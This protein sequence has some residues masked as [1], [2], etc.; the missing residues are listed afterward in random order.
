MF[1]HLLASTMEGGLD[2]NPIV[3]QNA[4]TSSEGRSRPAV[5]GKIWNQHPGVAYPI[6]R[7]G[8]GARPSTA[9]RA[10]MTNNKR[11][12]ASDS[13]NQFLVPGNENMFLTPHQNQFK[14]LGLMSDGSEMRAGHKASALM[15]QM[16][17][18]NLKRVTV[19]LSISPMR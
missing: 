10:I 5:L 9:R 17:A 1:L 4:A 6:P 15:A 12:S 16:L 19:G 18:V 13:D 8:A 7:P 2:H 11:C 14:S 3:A